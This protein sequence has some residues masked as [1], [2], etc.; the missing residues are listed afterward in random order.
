ML[1]GAG[2]VRDWPVEQALRDGRVFTVYEGASG[3]QALD[4]LHRRLWRD[5]GEGLAAFMDLAQAEGGAAL[6]AVLALLRDAA[7]RLSAVKHRPRE[8]EA[9]ASAFLQLAGLA[10]TG[11]IAQ[12]LTGLPDPRLAAAGAYWLSDLPSRAALEHARATAGAG[13]LAGFETLKA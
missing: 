12:R 8:G 13:R 3:M 1:G 9:G 2:Y 11:W 7:A 5:Q 6:P 4:L 10:A